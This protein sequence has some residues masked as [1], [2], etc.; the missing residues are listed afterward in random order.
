MIYTLKTLMEKLNDLGAGP[1]VKL[2][3]I[4]EKQKELERKERHSVSA[5]HAIVDVERHGDTI[6]LTY[7]D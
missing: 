4:G 2:A 7:R 1:D 3:V 6:L 5:H